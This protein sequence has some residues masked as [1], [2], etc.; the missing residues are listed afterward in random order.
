MKVF[1]FGLLMF[2][3]S[4]AC[5]SSSNGRVVEIR[6]SATSNA[7]LFKVDGEIDG[8]PR[9]NEWDMYSIDITS[10]EGRAVFELVKFALLEDLTIEVNGLGACRHHWKS[11]DVKNVSVG[12]D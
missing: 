11:E 6:A 12:K 5:A 9:C 2:F 7:V 1:V 10:A 8:F 4:V 3:A